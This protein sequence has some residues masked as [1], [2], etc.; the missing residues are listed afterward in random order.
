MPDPTENDSV[1]VV[2]PAAVVVVGDGDG[3][4]GS[5]TGG[6]SNSQRKLEMCLTRLNEKD[7]NKRL[8]IKL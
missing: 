2:V 7:N 3:R 5:T 1:G 6:S 4:A 8:Q